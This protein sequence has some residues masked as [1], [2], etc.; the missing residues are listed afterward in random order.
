M[1]T[2]AVS[3]FHKDELTQEELRQWLD[4]EFSAISDVAHRDGGSQL[5]SGNTL[6]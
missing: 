6:N 3:V 1:R 5:R 2:L 4:A